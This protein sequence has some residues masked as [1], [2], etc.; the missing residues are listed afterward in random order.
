MRDAAPDTAAVDAHAGAAE[1]FSHLR[2]RAGTI[3][4]LNAEIFHAHNVIA[5]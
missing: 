5:R 1:R 3:V 2:E 4:E